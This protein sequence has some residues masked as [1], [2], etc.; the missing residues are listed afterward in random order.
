VE[1]IQ[2]IQQAFRDD[3][4]S[5]TQIKEWYNRFKDGSTSVDREPRHGRPSTS[6]NECHQPSADFGHAGPSYH[7]PRTGRRGRG[8]HL[9]GIYHFDCGFGLEESVRE[10]RAKA[11]NDGAEA[12]S[13]GNRTRH[14]GLRRK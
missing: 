3:A 13:P 2:K 8:M 14:A 12:A 1:T 9:I 6:R 7:C 4:M 11:A 10:I 5:I